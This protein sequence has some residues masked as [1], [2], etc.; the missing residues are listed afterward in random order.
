MIIN[1]KKLKQ[2]RKERGMTQ[3]EF[4][5]MVGVSMQSVYLWERGVVEPAIGSILLIATK[6]EIDPS[7]L[8][9]KEEQ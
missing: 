4:A 5:D 7:E 8:W 6:L 1:P 9:K 2:L 3:Q